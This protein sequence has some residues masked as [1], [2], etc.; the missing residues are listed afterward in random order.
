MKKRL[1]SERQMKDLFS[2]SVFLVM[3]KLLTVDLN[4]KYPEAEVIVLIQDRTEK[5]KYLFLQDKFFS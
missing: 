3:V 1:E 5:N 4:A 2:N